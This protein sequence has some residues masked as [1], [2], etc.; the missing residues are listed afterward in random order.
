[1]INTIMIDISGLL[2]LFG[3]YLISNRVFYQWTCHTLHYNTVDV[4]IIIFYVQLDDKFGS[5]EQYHWFTI[6]FMRHP[7]KLDYWCY[8]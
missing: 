8:N 7:A 3:E 2:S 4:L 5:P 1:M 6:L